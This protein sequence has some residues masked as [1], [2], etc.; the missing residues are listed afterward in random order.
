MGRRKINNVNPLTVETE[1][2]HKK[3]LTRWEKF[4][5][6]L[7]Q[8]Y[9]IK[10]AGRLAGYSKTYVETGLYEKLRNPKFQ[11]E[12]RQFFLNH[13]ILEVPKV[14][15]IYRRTLNILDKEVDAGSLENVSKIKHIPKQILQMSGLLVEENKPATVSLVNIESL[16]AIIQGKLE[17]SASKTTNE[18]DD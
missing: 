1:D 2:E 6:Y 10:E 4:L 11:S 12:A 15:S 9:K 5:H 8:G 16:Q 13:N 14:L 3:E 18:D 7:G 17:L